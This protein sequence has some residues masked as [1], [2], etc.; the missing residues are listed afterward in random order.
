M[1]LLQM[2]G[3]SGSLAVRPTTRRRASRWVGILVLAL[4]GAA[5]TGCS[6][7]GATPG[8]TSAGPSDASGASSAA[9]AGTATAA[10]ATPG[11]AAGDIPPG[12]EIAEGGGGPVQYTF[13]EEWRKA[14]AEA[15][16]WRSGAYLISAT[17]FFINDEGVPSSWNLKFIDRAAAD[18]V[19]LIE[20]DPW[21][22]VTW[23]REI[24]G[25]EVS[26]FVNEF[27]KPIPY[28]IIDS[29]QAVSLGKAELGAR[30][31]L[32][33]TKEPSLSLNFSRVD[34]S[35]PVWTYMLFYNSTAEY[36][37]AHMDAL[38]GEVTD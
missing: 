3:P 14:R 13:R 2:L 33:K 29:D 10:P 19:L 35:G 25:Q 18:A 37:S 6:S 16:K 38:T 15:Q 36:V 5:M 28:A 27:T 32:A 23:P 22:K 24:T 9:S 30:Y 17:G 12:R 31:P 1:A 11:T 8:S 21:G 20:I 26:S 4:A 34:G 7:G